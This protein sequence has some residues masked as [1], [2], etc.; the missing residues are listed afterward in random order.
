MWMKESKHA[1]QV[2]EREHEEKGILERQSIAA[3]TQGL[4]SLQ[5]GS[6]AVAANARADKA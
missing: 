5:K 4:E 1:K 3:Y 6:K 2:R